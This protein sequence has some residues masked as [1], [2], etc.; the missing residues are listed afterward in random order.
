MHACVCMYACVRMHSCVCLCVRVHAFVYAICVCVC[1][2]VLV[3]ILVGVC[4][5]Y[6]RVLTRSTASGG[7]VCRGEPPHTE[8]RRARAAA[9]LGGYSLGEGAV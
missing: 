8:W 1:I 4:V 3:C 5:Y 6:V 2:F 7:R 9:G